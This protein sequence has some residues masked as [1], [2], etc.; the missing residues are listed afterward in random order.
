VALWLSSAPYLTRS[1]PLASKEFKAGR[2][3][4]M[5]RM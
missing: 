5:Y 1:V 3:M 4:V 2:A